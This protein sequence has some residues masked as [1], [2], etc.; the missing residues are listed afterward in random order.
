MAYTN[1]VSEDLVPLATH[2]PLTRQTATHV[3]DWVSMEGYH[4]AWLFV[5]IGAMGAGT[6][7]TAGIEQASDATGTGVKAITGKVLTSLTQAGSD[8]NSLACIELQTEELDVSGGFEYIRFYTTIAG[9]DVSYEATLFGTIARYKPVP[10]SA[11]DEV[12]A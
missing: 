12:V 1:R 4:R 11:W 7:F 3:S 2:Y 5:S 9:G 6:T 10:I 8:A